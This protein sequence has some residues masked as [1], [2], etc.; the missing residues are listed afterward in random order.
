MLVI[1]FR[2][3]TSASEPTAVE[4]CHINGRTK[5]RQGPLKNSRFHDRVEG[6]ADY[7]I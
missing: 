3:V 2:P 1:M 5:E 6:K 4:P 7:C